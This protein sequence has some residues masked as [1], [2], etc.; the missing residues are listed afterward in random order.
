MANVIIE[1]EDEDEDLPKAAAKPPKKDDL[2]DD[3]DLSLFTKKKPVFDSDGEED[4]GFE[5]PKP[6][7]KFESSFANQSEEDI[8]DMEKYRPHNFESTRPKGDDINDLMDYYSKYKTNRNAM[9]R[10][11]NAHGQVRSHDEEMDDVAT[12]NDGFEKEMNWRKKYSDPE[13]SYV[14]EH[15]PPPPRKKYSD[16]DDIGIERPYERTKFDFSDSIDPATRL[17]L[18]KNNQPGRPKMGM[19]YDDDEPQSNGYRPPPRPTKENRNY[20]SNFEDAMQMLRPSPPKLWQF[21]E[22]LWRFQSTAAATTAIYATAATSIWSTRS[23]WRWWSGPVWYAGG[24]WSTY[25]W[26]ATD[27][28]LWPGVWGNGQLCTTTA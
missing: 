16:P 13:Q 27:A 11:T 2:M 25:V 26:S 6:G 17:I 22:K 23:L 15:E 9:G 10:L 18:M 24:I 8:M 4:F 1:E 21:G 12:T 28:A 14:S 7:K 20:G 3:A 5:R 19:N